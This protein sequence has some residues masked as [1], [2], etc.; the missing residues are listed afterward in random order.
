MIIAKY[1]IRTS[2]SRNGSVPKPAIS[3][4]P[5]HPRYSPQARSISQS[6]EDEAPHNYLAVAGSDQLAEKRAWKADRIDVS[7][8]WE[9][10][11]NDIGDAPF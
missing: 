5:I 2:H 7:Q 4:L 9:N 8:P 6:I 10:V 1:K 11:G 3:I